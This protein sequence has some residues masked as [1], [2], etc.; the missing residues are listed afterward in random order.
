[1]RVYRLIDAAIAAL[2]KSKQLV[3][4]TD[5]VTVRADELE[6]SVA[7]VNESGGV[8]SRS[9]VV[10]RDLG[11]DPSQSVES[12]PK[13]DGVEPDVDFDTPRDYELPPSID[14][15]VAT[16]ARSVPRPT[17]TRVPPSSITIWPSGG[18]ID[19]A[20]G[21]SM[22]RASRTTGG[23]VIRLRS[24]LGDARWAT[25]W[26]GFANPVLDT[27]VGANGDAVGGSSSRFVQRSFIALMYV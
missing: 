5:H 4:S 15:T 9:C 1:V 6:A 19:E 14:R 18:P 20:A 2:R 12:P 27:A 21:V 24:G 22:S 7:E 8:P 16:V 23:R 10:A 3:R 26:I 25:R 13:I 17:I 11:D